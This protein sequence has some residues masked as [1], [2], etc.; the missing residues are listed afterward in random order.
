M[1]GSRRRVGCC[2]RSGADG[3]PCRDLSLRRRRGLSGDGCGSPPGPCVGGTKSVPRP[4]GACNGA[5]ALV[6]GAAGGALALGRG[7]LASVP[8]RARRGV[9]RHL[10]AACGLGGGGNGPPARS[11]GGAALGACRLWGRRRG[12]VD[13]GPDPPAAARTGSGRAAD[14]SS[15]PVGAG[16]GRTAAAGGA[17]R[18]AIAVAGRL[19]GA[20]DRGGPR[21]CHPDLDPERYGFHVGSAGAGDPGR[22]GGGMDPVADGRS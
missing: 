18:L 8:G 15:Q 6:A 3:L 17:R 12:G 11:T 1:A 10:L 20:L 14:R 9:D 21:G 4:P 19:A 13:L 16:A 2:V 7:K 22:R 5:G